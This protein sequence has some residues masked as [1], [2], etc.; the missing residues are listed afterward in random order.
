MQSRRGIEPLDSHSEHPVAQGRTM[1]GAG[2]PATKLRLEK[3]A[4]A[5]YSTNSLN[6]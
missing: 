5:H 6:S 4:I 1:F 3:P 2:L